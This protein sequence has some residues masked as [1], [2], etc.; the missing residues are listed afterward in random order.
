MLPDV[1]LMVVVCAGFTVAAA[2]NNPE[3]LIVPAVV[4]DEFHV[5]LKLMS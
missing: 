2:V 3:L 4:L 1:A 5:A